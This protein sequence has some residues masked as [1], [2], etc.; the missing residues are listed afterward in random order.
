M[1]LQGILCPIDITN[2]Y[3]NFGNEA[4]YLAVSEDV[5]ST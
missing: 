3:T 1:S 2:L 4:S 5:G